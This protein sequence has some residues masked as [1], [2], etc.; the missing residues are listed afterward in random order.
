MARI[1]LFGGTFDPVH[2]GHMALA[3]QVRKTMELDRI[4]LLPAGN[5]PHKPKEDITDKMHR[6]RMLEIATKSYPYFFVSDYEMRKE[7]PNYS[8]QTITDFKNMY[9]DDEIFFIVGGDSFRDF[10]KWKEYRK[11]LTL[12]PFIVV[13][14]PGVSPE[15]YFENFCGDETP[16]RVFFIRDAAYDISSTRVRSLLVAGEDPAVLLPEGVTAYIKEHRLYENT[17]VNHAL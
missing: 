3:E 9:P 11:L 10:P 12:C 6:F 8:Y 15:D 14:R 7:T 16:P 1:G 2:A 5:P 4:I 13:S 17:G